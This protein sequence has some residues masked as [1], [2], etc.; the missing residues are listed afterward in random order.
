MKP[1]KLFSVTKELCEKL[2]DPNSRLNFFFCDTTVNYQYEKIKKIVENGGRDSFY[3]NVDSTTFTRKFLGEK[4]NGTDISGSIQRLLESYYSWLVDLYLNKKF[5]KDKKI[6]I[7]NRMNKEFLT[8]NYA[9]QDLPNFVENY[10]K[11]FAD[12]A[13]KNTADAFCYKLIMTL[14][15]A[16]EPIR[17]TIKDDLTDNYIGNF[18]IDLCYSLDI[19]DSVVDR[20]MEAWVNKNKSPG[21]VYTLIID[22]L[23]QE[24]KKF[25]CPALIS[26]D[27]KKFTNLLKAIKEGKG[28]KKHKEL[29]ELL[30]KAYYRNQAEEISKKLTDEQKK[31]LVHDVLEEDELIGVLIHSKDLSEIKKINNYYPT[32]GGITCKDFY[33]AYYSI[34]PEKQKEVVGLLL[35]GF[36]IDKPEVTDETSNTELA[37]IV[38]KWPKYYREFKALKLPRD[39]LQLAQYM[40]IKQQSEM[41]KLIG[42]VLYCDENPLECVVGQA[43]NIQGDPH[44]IYNQIF[45]VIKACMDN[46]DSN[47][48]LCQQIIKELKQKVQDPIKSLNYEL[49]GRCYVTLNSLCSRNRIIGYI[50]EEK[51][52][53]ILINDSSKTKTLQELYNKLKESDEN[54][55]KAKE[56][57][58]ITDSKADAMGVIRE[59]L[60][61]PP[62]VLNELLKDLGLKSLQVKN[63]SGDILYTMFNNLGAATPSLIKDIR[64][65]LDIVGSLCHGFEEV[66]MTSNYIHTHAIKKIFKNIVHNYD[67]KQKQTKLIAFF[68]QNSIEA[69]NFGEL[70]DD[71]VLKLIR[72]VNTIEIETIN[73][74][75][76]NILMNDKATEE[77]RDFAETDYFN[78]VNSCYLGSESL[79]EHLSTDR[80]KRYWDNTLYEK[81]K[82]SEKKID[83]AEGK[84][85]WTL[86]ELYSAGEVNEQMRQA[87][88]VPTIEPA[89]FQK[90]VELAM[91]DE[92]PNSL[93]PKSKFY[94]WSP[95]AWQMYSEK[96]AEWYKFPK[97]KYPILTVI[98][99]WKEFADKWC[100]DPDNQRQWTNSV[101]CLIGTYLNDR[102]DILDTRNEQYMTQER[103]LNHPFVIAM[104][105]FNELAK[106]LGINDRA[107]LEKLPENERQ[108]H[109]LMNLLNSMRLLFFTTRN[110]CPDEA[111]Y[112]CASWEDLIIDTYYDVGNEKPQHPSPID[113]T[114]PMDLKQRFLDKICYKTRKNAREF[115]ILNDPAAIHPVY[116]AEIGKQMSVVYSKALNVH[117]EFGKLDFDI[118][119]LKETCGT[120]EFV[121]PNAPNMVRA[122]N[123]SKSLTL[124]SVIGNASEIT[125]TEGQKDKEAMIEITNQTMGKERTF[126]DLVRVF[127]DKSLLLKTNELLSDKNK[128]YFGDPKDFDESWSL[129]SRLKAYLMD[130]KKYGF[131]PD[132]KEIIE[133]IK[134]KN[135]ADILLKNTKTIALWKQLRNKSITLEGVLDKI[136]KD[137]D[138]YAPTL[139]LKTEI[140]K[141]ECWISKG[142]K[143]TLNELVK[144]LDCVAKEYVVDDNDRELMAKHHIEHVGRTFTTDILPLYLVDSEYIE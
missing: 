43:K 70:S 47:Q 18:G 142:T 108:N 28:S 104:A 5:D 93:V 136:E 132:A 113:L 20:A 141:L 115:M 126:E 53:Y 56:L 36:L 50:K 101:G 124:G 128:Y 105:M 64:E 68:K 58:K 138:S 80:G 54:L 109:P 130:L 60:S 75:V 10:S 26:K 14:K 84:C 71:E 86:R 143:M 46:N 119:T 114:P 63:Y 31:Q 83:D 122:K 79:S 96:I 88:G 90:I 15:E 24:I 19:L 76:F 131:E 133:T 89:H 72:S 117:P 29:I 7:K 121:T 44:S 67:P 137:M 40:G 33:R 144:I 87:V 34:E 73:S 97:D 37:K 32:S 135:D 27:D 98:S 103:V 116:A 99:A 3:E 74:K 102:L 4:S 38:Y 49:L 91:K 23:N 100:V 85:G 2:S 120:A 106:K 9:L 13:D 77:V 16:F 111:G 110:H 65:Q 45:Y 123:A 8:S 1:D 62:N 11:D 22:Q 21:E 66:M 25:N 55:A 12:I 69:P 30:T 57:L 118:T 48:V 51:T 52:P 35:S 140:D 39:W 6:E 129:R 125:K 127:D 95:P 112:M 107:E 139:I 17:I 59:I 92:S 134:E 82:I 61:C 81:G 41:F 94:E 78:K 42:Y